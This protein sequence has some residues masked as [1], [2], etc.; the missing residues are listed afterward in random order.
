LDISQADLKMSYSEALLRWHPRKDAL[1]NGGGIGQ[2]T[3]ES[4]NQIPM[5]A[6]PFH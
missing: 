2:H 3:F 1:F 5:L 6:S 4:K